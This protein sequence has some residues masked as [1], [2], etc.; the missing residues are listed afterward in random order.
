MVVRQRKQVA[1]S[2]D[3]EERKQT[4]CADGDGNADGERMEKNN[5][6]EKKNDIINEEIVTFTDTCE[7]THIRKKE[8]KRK[9]PD[10]VILKLNYIFLALASRHPWLVD[11]LKGVILLIVFSLLYFPT[12]WFVLDPARGFTYEDEDVEVK[13]AVLDKICPPGIECN[14][15]NLDLAD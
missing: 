12:K 14:Y 3:E 13:K 7:D 9:S 1:M 8:K 6:V 4:C 11:V 15:G 10:S 5:C 2:C